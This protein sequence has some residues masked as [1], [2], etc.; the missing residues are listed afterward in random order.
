MVLADS[1]HRRMMMG[2]SRV[3]MFA[4]CLAVLLAIP[5]AC[6]RAEKE[7]ASP[8]FE[9]HDLVLKQVLVETPPRERLVAKSKE[10]IAWKGKK[11]YPFQLTMNEWKEKHEADNIY[12][13]EPDTFWFS[14]EYPSISGMEDLALE[15]KINQLIYDEI[16]SILDRQFQVSSESGSGLELERSCYITLMTDEYLSIRFDG[17]TSSRRYNRLYEMITIDLKSVRRLE[18]TDFFKPNTKPAEL[19]M[20]YCKKDLKRQYLEH[21]NKPIGEQYS[22]CI[23]WQVTPENCSK[24]NL[25]QTGFFLVFDELFSKAEGRWTVLVPYDVFEDECKLTAFWG[26]YGYNS[27]E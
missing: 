4:L 24:V 26:A 16:K 20:D 8:S 15:E 19:I 23:D 18:L 13:S 6:S 9:H 21:Y 7:V 11:P 25:T 14:V 22:M 1:V 12:S 27:R 10:K 3:A 2:R 5:V 17:H